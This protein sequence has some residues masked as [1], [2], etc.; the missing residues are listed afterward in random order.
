MDTLS[1][2]IRY[3]PIRVGW[4]LRRGN[5]EA[6]RKAMRTS[7]ALWGGAYSPIIP[8][9]DPN[10]AKNLIA[11]F[12][13]DV[14]WPLDTDKAVSDFVERFPHLPN[15]FFH[16][17]IFIDEGEGNRA[18]Q[19]LDIYHPARRLYEEHFRNNPKPEVS[20]RIHTWDRGD[21]LADVLLAT[22]GDVPEVAESGTDYC[23]VLKSELHASDSRI[24]KGT[25]LPTPSDA[26]WPL[27]A[28]GR[29]YLKTHYSISSG[30]NH[31]GFYIG[32]AND[33][34]DLVTF[35]NLRATNKR[36]QFF[37]PT[38]A[39]RFEQRRNRWLEQ[40][41][42]RAPERDEHERSVAI[43]YLDR[44]TA[45]DVKA[46]GTGLTLCRVSEA[47]WNGL[48]VKAPYMY[49]AEGNALATVGK[50][51]RGG[52]S[53]SFQLP[54]PSL[55]DDPKLYNQHLVIGIDPGIGL[56]GDERY[57]LHPPYLPE[58]N[59][60]LGRE[61]YFEWNK[62]RSEPGGVGIISS[63]TRADLSIRALPTTELIQ[64]VFG[65]A[66][67][68][69][70]TSKPGLIATRLIQQ[71]GGLDGCRVFK[72]AGVRELIEG[73]DPQQ[74][75]TRGHA[76]RTIWG[77]GTDAP[78]SSYDDLYIEGRPA[79]NVLTSDAV[80]AYLLRKSVFR[81]GLQFKCP[82]CQLEFW[83][84]LDDVA[85][86]TT[87]EYCGH[88]FNVSPFLKDRDWA[89]RRSGLFGRDDHQQG[90]IPVVLTLQQLA[91]AASV[92]SLQYTTAMTLDPLRTPI[93]SCE[94]DFASMISRRDKIEIAV[95]ECKT[96]GEITDDDVEKMKAV[97][98]AFPRDRFD[99]YVVFAKLAPFT[100]E[101]IERAGRLNDRYRRR[102]ILLTRRE[103]EPYFI[104]KRAEKEIGERL[105]A[106][107]LSDMAKATERLFLRK[108]PPP[109]TATVTDPDPK[110]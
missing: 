74:S 14:L 13:V 33:F 97:A 57:T 3:R 15:P 8:V 90:A 56:F 30:W 83:V 10:L 71:M 2:T 76:T 77:E 81:T 80:F 40:L 98:D 32:S 12:R 53:V 107:S 93:R 24:D 22:Y 44:G 69:A 101:E 39:P 11:L 105:V 19:L 23:A 35:W 72:I 20:V 85:T 59:E 42:S 26:E 64:R 86:E 104:Y 28:F 18:S 31:P 47:T 49:F 70:E 46:F 21:P 91:R 79:G 89:H 48:N 60:Y 38:H 7:F 41:R 103:L 78:L 1:L 65:V 34:D 29:A 75:F 36:L 63:A 61:Y 17:E 27:S 62:A 50:S 4:C 92:K 54:S 108:A 25:I 84:A 82:S 88:R 96:R 99:P 67:I 110:P 66:G 5:L 102:L 95:G 106:V 87:C 51:S 100:A 6:L 58:L 55:S 109:P 73:H 43:W 68:K 45:P 94:T 37:D 16:D 9:D 52:P